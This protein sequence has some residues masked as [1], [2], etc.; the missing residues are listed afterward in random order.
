M[1]ISGFTNDN[2]YQQ[3]VAQ[4]ARG[5]TINADPADLHLVVS[6]GLVMDATLQDG[7]PWTLGGYVQE[8][9]GVSARSKKTFGIYIPLDVEEEETLVS[10]E[11]HK[12]LNSFCSCLLMTLCRLV[13]K[14][15]TVPRERQMKVPRRLKQVN[16]TD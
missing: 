3:V 15:V 2:T 10:S 16:C 7:R 8:I 11:M 9:G 5:M 12:L 13:R 4:G 6:G 1:Q 14:Q